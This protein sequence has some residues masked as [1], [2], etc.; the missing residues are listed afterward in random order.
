M[1][2]KLLFPVFLIFITIPADAQLN[3]KGTAFYTVMPISQET[4]S[5]HN[6]LAQS[7]EPFSNQISEHL[8]FQLDFNPNFA[9]FTLS[10]SPSLKKYTSNSI[11]LTSIQYGYADTVWQNHEAAYSKSHE[12][13]G[14]KTIVLLKQGFHNP[15]WKISNQKKQIG[16]FTCFKATKT[17]I[18][19]RGPRIFSMPL[20]AWFCPEIPV[21][22][23]PNDFGGLPGLILEAQTDKFL[24]GLKSIIFKSEVSVNKIPAYPAYTEEELIERLYKKK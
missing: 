13:F 6:D 21:P 9:R 11:Q 22:Y 2:Y 16:N 5:Q 12:G 7:L 1:L 18:I 8:I 23:G 15:E 19:K 17:N 3:S 4:T 10:D 20:I 24:Y 14:K